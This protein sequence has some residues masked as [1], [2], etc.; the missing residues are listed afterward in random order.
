MKGSIADLIPLMVI[1]GGFGLMLFIGSMLH[2]ALQG[3]D[4]MSENVSED[5]TTTF[6]VLDQGTIFLFIGIGIA[7]AMGVLSIRVSPVFIIPV[8]IVIIIMVM[9]SANVS[10]VFMEVATSDNIITEADKYEYTVHAMA[11]MPWI[12]GV[13]SLI[14][15]V[16]IFAKPG[17]GKI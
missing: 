3:T 13:L 11:Y 2:T 6:T 8:I 9:L 7:I 12:V 14:I 10:N 5:L 15:F 4:L 17:G 1:I 16:A